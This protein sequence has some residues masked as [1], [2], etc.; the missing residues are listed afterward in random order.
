MALSKD[1]SKKEKKQSFK[2][3]GSPVIQYGSYKLPISPITNGMGAT[4]DF[5]QETAVLTVVKDNIT[6]MINFIEKTVKINGTPDLN[7]GIFTVKNKKKKTVLIKYIAKVLGVRADTEK[8]KV[9]VTIPELDVPN[10]VSIIPVGTDT[11]KNTLNAST[12]YLLVTA[13][14][15]AGQAA[16][17]RAEL[18]IGNRFITA[19]MEITNTDTSVTFTTSDGTPTNSELQTMVPSGGMV[20]V[21]LYNSKNQ[22]INSS[23]NNPTLDV[24]Y[25]IPAISGVSFAT[26]SI[27]DSVL[28]ISVTG[29]STVNDQVD[30]TKISITDTALT[31]TYQL[32]AESTGIISNDTT[33][34]IHLCTADLLGLYNFGSSTVYL[35][36]AP[37]PLLKDKAGNRSVGFASAQTVPVILTK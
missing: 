24:D 3:N 33:L 21:K 19:D 8:D 10:D 35:T 36:L 32:T 12:L 23:K 18:Y 22:Y 11:F 4:V 9:I 37:G 16:G 14:I 7:S 6:I 34:T 30:V 29:A 5:N 20:T 31:K 13:K 25:S 17:G 1:C 26:C 27:L 15:K 28:N 2:I